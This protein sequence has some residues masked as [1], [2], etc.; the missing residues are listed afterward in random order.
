[1]TIWTVETVSATMSAEKTPLRPRARY[2]EV[3]VY[4]LSGVHN[5]W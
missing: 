4:M 2:A 5:A 1:M 3:G